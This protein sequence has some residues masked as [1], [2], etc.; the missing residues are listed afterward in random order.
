MKKLINDSVLKSSALSRLFMH[1]PM[2]AIMFI[3]LT[4]CAEERTNFTE[5]V[6]E[7]DFIYNVKTLNVDAVVENHLANS[8]ITF[9]QLA[10]C[11]NTQTGI[12]KEFIPIAYF[13]VT[14]SK[15]LIEVTNDEELPIELVESKT[16]SS[17]PVETDD[18]KGQDIIM[19]FKF[20]DG[21]VATASFGY[22]FKKETVNDKTVYT[23]HIEFD[24]VNFID[25]TL[26]KNGQTTET[27]DP[28][29]LTLNF[30]VSYKD[31]ET[32]T[33]PKSYTMVASPWY[34]KVITTEPTVIES[35]TYNGKYTGTPIDA[36]EVT[37]IVVTNKTNIQ[38]TYRLPLTYSFNAPQ[39]REQPTS[40]NQFNSKSTGST[41]ENI[42]SETKNLDGFTVRTIN[43]TH[44]SSNTGTK[45]KTFVES[46]ATF[47]Y[48]TPIKLETEYGTHNIEPLS[49]TF[50]E[51]KFTITETSRTETLITYQ[52]FNY[53]IPTIVVP[54]GVN[55][56]FNALVEEVILKETIEIPDVVVTNITYELTGNGDT[57]I[58]KK[59]THWSN[60][61]TT[62]SSYD[63]TGSH[64]ITSV[65]FGE[66]ITSSLDWTATSLGKTN[67]TIYKTDEKKFS[68]TTKFVAV[69]SNHTHTSTA[70][71]ASQS[72]T[73][74]FNELSPVVTFIDGNVEKTF[75]VR[76]YNIED[77]GA[78]L[79]TNRKEVTRNSVA[80]YAYDYNYTISCSWDKNPAETIISKGSLLTKADTV[81]ETVYD[82]TQTWYNN[83]TTI[84]VTKTIPHS[85]AN[86]EVTTFETNFTI[87][88]KDLTN[89]T[90]YADNTSFS[91]TRSLTSENTVPSTDGYFTINKRTRT[92][93]FVLSNG[94]NSRTM[95]T[96]VI[97]AEI[98]FND[99]TF[100][101]TFDVKLNL[102][103][104]SAFGTAFES[105]GYFV[106]PHTL[107]LTAKTVDNKTLTTKGLTNIYL[108]KPESTYTAEQTWR[109]NTTL[110]TVTKTTPSIGGS[111]IVENYNAEF[112]ISLKDL[113]N[114]FI[115][116]DNTSFSV[117]RSL[118]SENTVPST[119]GYFTINKRT[120]TY[121]F[122]LS[123]GT[124]SRTMPTEVIDAE[125]S[126][127]DGTF[128]KTFDVKLNLNHDGS[129]GTT[130]ENGNYNVTPHT[131][132]LSAQSVDNK[133]LTTKGI[134]DIYV[135][136]PEVEPEYPHLGKPTGFTVTATFDPQSK[137]TRRAFCFNWE[138]GVTYA[139]CDYET[140]LP[141]DSD[142]M[143]KIDNYTNYNS[144]GYNK[145]NPSSPWEPARGVDNS[146]FIVWYSSDST[147]ISAIDKAVT[148]KSI[149]WK[150][151]I[152]GVYSLVIEGY[153]Y[154]IN[155][156]NIT[157]IAPNGE[158]VTF[159]SH[160]NQ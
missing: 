66:V 157:I 86:D 97:D 124:N 29:K 114:D 79:S 51:D 35:V 130:Y 92:Y 94:T 111:N 108:P 67:T 118:T 31:K 99:G 61:T 38:K 75:P 3:A 84:K 49:V 60:D 16:L 151:I 160:Y 52:T 88:L 134:T 42:A 122:V 143:F 32:T 26:E 83:T 68:D 76:G 158:T 100:S 102:S 47:T 133:I 153:T 105:N 80:Y 96:E 156:Y 129:F 149:G 36:Y 137:V 54:N 125:I 147:M 45:N 40:D 17:T 112:T 46:V 98:S 154:T 146:D 142:F 110:I 103:H 138:D 140:M 23:P 78:T 5:I 2:L 87:S 119:D 126:F 89:D 58:V 121:D 57:Y 113:T 74:T 132:K 73:F 50:K 15:E 34:Q 20:S 95:P 11:T 37:E 62:T 107:N 41:N 152:N 101:K 127:N 24:G 19:S 91:V 65:D 55:S 44:T 104:D 136:I 56:V 90:L 71:N 77:K 4:S 43:G 14:L 12:T 53:V 18:E 9:D 155:G 10:T 150:N 135:E 145:N 64:S 115:Y 120:R 85:H 141:K 131:L 22:R 117:T 13:N 93:D 28:Y 72:G 69:Y 33:E 109:G 39:K 21:Q 25:Y 148:C 7:P 82:Y 106:T 128:S 6:P 159:N 144:V 116:A 70:T 48:E 81:G 1:V 30:K 139:V 8:V 27:D 59:I 123:N 63:Y